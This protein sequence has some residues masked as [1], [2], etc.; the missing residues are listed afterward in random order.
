MHVLVRDGLIEDVSDVPL[1]SS[2]APHHRPARRDADA[3]PD[4]LPRACRRHRGQSRQERAA[5]ELAGR[6]A[7]HRHHARHADA[8]L[9]H[10][11]RSRR[12]RLSAC[13]RRW[14]TAPSSARASSSA[15]RASRRPAVTRIFAAATT[16]G[17]PSGSPASSARSGASSMASTHLRAR[18]PRGDQ[19]RRPVHQADGQWRRRVADRPDQFLRLLARRDPRMAVEEAEMAQ[20]YVA[21]HLYTAASIKRADRMRRRMRRARQPRRC[22]GREAH[23]RRTARSRC[24]R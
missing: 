17:R 15:A 21:G 2:H 10:R 11:P 5:A 19:G 8:R 12:R 13:S 1:R 18:H 7:R 24:R 4:R 6:R 3:R 20:T 22:R 14:R 9:H 23:R 16:P